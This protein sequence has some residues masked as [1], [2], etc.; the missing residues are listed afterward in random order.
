MKTEYYEEIKNLIDQ[1][2]SPVDSLLDESEYT[3]KKYLEDVYNEVVN[4]LPS[5]WIHRSSVYEALK[6]LGFKSFLYTFP[7]V[8]DKE[9]NEI[10]PEKSAML[11]LMD[12]KTAAI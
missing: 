11:Y 8:E 10:F 2:Y 5:E 1:H 9:G 6:E 12:T 7:A 3:K 4:I